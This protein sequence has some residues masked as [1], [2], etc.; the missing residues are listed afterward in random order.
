MPMASSFHRSSRRAEPGSILTALEP[1]TAFIG[2]ADQVLYCIG[3]NF[4]DASV[5]VINGSDR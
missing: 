5:I 4:T 2:G 1:T 3:D